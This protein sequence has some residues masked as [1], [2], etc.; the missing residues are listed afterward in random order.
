MRVCFVCK[1]LLISKM[2]MSQ[3]SWTCGFETISHIIKHPENFVICLFGNQ[4][5]ML[6]V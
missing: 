3:I 5:K 4:K 6:V 2:S 1:L